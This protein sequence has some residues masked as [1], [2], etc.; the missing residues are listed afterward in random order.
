MCLCRNLCAFAVFAVTCECVFPCSSEED[1]QQ[2]VS[3]WTSTHTNLVFT[4]HIYF[5]LCFLTQLLSENH[6]TRCQNFMCLF[7]PKVDLF[8]CLWLTSYLGA[9]F[10][11]LLKG[12]R[13]VTLKLAA[14]SFSF[15]LETWTCHIVCNPKLNPLRAVNISANDPLVS[16]PEL[17]YI[18]FQAIVSSPFLLSSR[19]PHAAV[20]LPPSLCVRDRERQT[21]RHRWVP[22]FE[23]QRKKSD[24]WNVVKGL[25]KSGCG[26]VRHRTEAG[27]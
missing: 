27:K 3:G 16:F 8:C 25:G 23:A 14:I 12:Q 26:L 22:G 6:I 17:L 11:L 15:A 19:R 18:Y 24:T 21:K 13:S 10:L 9:G 4:H 2:L 1:R 5:N 7:Y 20:R